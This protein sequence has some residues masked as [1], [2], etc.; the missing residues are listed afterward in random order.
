MRGRGR[1]RQ[2]GSIQ[3]ERGSG[4]S[5]LLP[6]GLGIALAQSSEGSEIDLGDLFED[7]PEAERGGTPKLVIVEIES[8]DIVGKGQDCVKEGGGERATVRLR[9]RTGVQT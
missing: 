3:R 6:V 7:N 9:G 5:H 4:G 1:L 8:C 2:L